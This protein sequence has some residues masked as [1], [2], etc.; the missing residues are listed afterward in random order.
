MK[1]NLDKR[2][3]IRYPAITLDDYGAPVTTWKLLATVWADMQDALPS[4]S[5]SVTQG[6]L[7]QGKD[8]TRIRVRHIPTLDSSMH[9]EHDGVVYNIV[10]GPAVMG[11]RKEYQEIMVERYTT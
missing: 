5:E 10:G 4:R 3:T 6:V 11:T 7:K 9:V 2:I 8:Q 1:I